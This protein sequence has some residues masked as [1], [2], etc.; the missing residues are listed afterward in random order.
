MLSGLSLMIR[1]LLKTI[2]NPFFQAL[3]LSVAVVLFVPLGLQKYTAKEVEM[4]TAFDK[5]QFLFADLDH[6]GVSE[7]VHTFINVA[8]NAGLSV[9]EGE[10]AMGQWNYKGIWQPKTHRLMIGDFNH[11]G[12]DEIYLFTL[13]NDS[14]MLHAV[15]YD[16]KPTPFIDHRF[17]A[18][19]GKNLQDPDILILPG[20][21]TDM[22]G[23][24]FGDL[25][26]AV[27][28]GFSKYPRNVFIYDIVADSLKVSP[29]SGAFI[30]VNHS[31][32]LYDLNEDGFDEI[33]LHTYASDNFMSAPIP[34][35]DSS[36]WIMV[37]DHELNFLFPPVEFPGMTGS[38]QIFP[39]KSSD[40]TMLI[41]GKYSH[42][43]PF[44]EYSSIFLA[45]LNGSI[46]KE[47]KFLLDDPFFH[48][49][50]FLY[51]NNKIK[52]YEEHIGFVQINEALEIN[53]ISNLALSMRSPELLDIDQDGMNEI[54]ILKP[55]QQKHQILRNDFF[56]PVDLDF[57]LQSE[58]IAF[59]VKL[60]GKNPPQ[61]SV[62]GDQV[63]KL[64]DY[65]INTVYRLRFLI[66]T[67]IYLI[68]LAFITLIRQLYAVQLKKRY[69][70]E[71]KIAGL[72]LASVKTQMEPH[73]IF[74]VINSIGS[75]IYQEKKDEAYNLVIRFSN[76]VRYLLS[77]SDQL[78]R[79]LNDEVEFVRNYL[80]LEKQRFPEIFDYEISIDE[81]LD[82]EK[83]VP[84]MIIQ[85]HAENAIK[86]GLRPK[87]EKGKIAIH[88]QS[89]DAFLVI[90][91]K[92][93]GIGR[94]ASA[95]STSDS[96]GKG[97]KLLQQLFDTYNKHNPV[98]LKQEITDLYDENQHPAGTLITVYIPI[99][100]NT[101]I[102]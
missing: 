86:H 44:I 28:A 9:R 93:N 26:F 32:W 82:L 50:S 42:S 17:I 67:G 89:G 74:N 81:D 21:V 25:V 66:Y 70:T 14:I 19:V 94:Q 58:N 68:I 31:S 48:V 99:D 6:D 59:S 78:Y 98:P 40:G 35:S 29:T 15:E 49:G 41:W 22:T 23:D 5:T 7:R 20:K 13:V 100:F 72:Q 79:T 76:M 18:L 96:T 97:M 38:V 88:I 84:K 91:I 46:V 95:K 8:G 39:L 62:Q 60:N 11:N 83:P 52:G 47:R 45:D 37:L 65:G 61:L 16:I 34:Y 27:N 77:T 87:K 43:N 92:D 36:A 69:E 1:P 12:L 53:K 56:H 90:T 55:G 33:M 24:G 4:I 64:F 54:I 10:N 101:E 63:W 2:L 30:N 85:L 73:F 102:L 80:E 75:S 57:P 51:D 71:R 3:I